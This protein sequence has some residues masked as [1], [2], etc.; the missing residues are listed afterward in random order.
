VTLWAI[1]YAKRKAIHE[2]IYQSPLSTHNFVTNFVADLQLTQLKVK[3]RLAVQRSNI[4]WIPSP[5]GPMKINVDAALAKNS[6]TIVAAAVTRD[7]AGHF[8]GASVVVMERSLEPEM[9]E[10][11]SCKEGLA[12]A[13]AICYSRTS[14]WHVTM[15]VLSQAYVKIVWAHYPEN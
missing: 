8:L 11:I 9:V 2:N 4:R 10:A 1:W 6:G 14:E 15:L 3:D 12:L 5:T 13:S 7:F